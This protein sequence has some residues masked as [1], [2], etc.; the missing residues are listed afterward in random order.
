MIHPVRKLRQQRNIP[1]GDAAKQLG[2]SKPSLCRIE[3][4]QQGVSDVLKRRIIKW[5][6]GAITAHDLVNF[7]WKAAA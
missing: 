3:L 4:G 1:L 5:S 6:R 7:R 2:I